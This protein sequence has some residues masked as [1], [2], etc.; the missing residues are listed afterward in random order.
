MMTPHEQEV[1]GEIFE[2]V[3]AL[4]PEE[5]RAAVERAAAGTPELRD[6]LLSLEASYT[7]APDF[8]EGVPGKVLSRMLNAL[9]DAPED[10]SRWPPVGARYQ[11]IERLGQ[12]GMG[13]VYKARDLRL[14]RLVALKLL[15]AHL[16]ADEKAR[17]RLLT[18]ARA[19]SMLDHPNIAVVHE[20]DETES[21]QLFISMACHEG[22]TLRQRLER[23]PLP[24]LEAIDIG[25]QVASALATTHAAAI[26]HRDI[27]PSNIL[28]T[29]EGVV[30]ILDFGIAKAAG[31]ELTREGVIV[32]TVAYM[33][34]EQTRSE[35]TDPSTDV[36]SLG[37]VLYQMLTSTRPFRADS[38]PALVHAIRYDPPLPIE[39]FRAD[40]PFALRGVVERCLAKHPEDR[41]QHASALA[42]DLEAIAR[43]PAEAATPAEV[44]RPADAPF[45]LAVLPIVD[46]ALDPRHSGIAAALTPELIAA[47]SAISGLRITAMA[48]VARWRADAAPSELVDALGVDG[49]V[50]GS[51]HATGS[52][53]H[54]RLELIDC[55][56]AESLWSHG[57]ESTIAQLGGSICTL[58]R[59]IAETLQIR[60]ST[61]EER[62]MLGARSPEHDAYRC[63]LEARPMLDRWDREA[64]NQAAVLFRRAVEADPAFAHAWSG[65]AHSLTKL[66]GLTA[67]TPT[68]AYSQARAAAERAL[69]LNEELPEAHT[70]LATALSYH[71]LEPRG[72]ERHFQ[73]AIELD[74]SHAA[75]RGFYAELLRN[76]GRFTE[77][78]TQIKAAQEL[79]PS[80][81]AH[82]FEEGLI[83][84]VARRYDEAHARL[85]R[86]LD[87]STGFHVAHFGMALVL[88]QLGRF[89]EALA[90]L[91]AL[92]PDVQSPDARSLRGYI[93]ARTGR[94]TEAETMIALLRESLSDFQRPF[95]PSPFHA[96]VILVGLGRFDEG[97]DL[98]WELHRERTWHAGLLKVEPMLDPLRTQ[99]RF[100]RLLEALGLHQPPPLLTPISRPR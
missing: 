16:A 65:L 42:A 93:Y 70:A 78:L 92:D 13:V 11:I 76:Q 41:Y 87:A 68:E 84:Y 97:L 83:L 55:R 54:T 45:R 36:W 29:R 28:I 99:P 100:Q 77:A 26:V 24:V 1:L 96:A 63:Y 49:C 98:L 74:P 44:V 50:R 64:A 53:I 69:E 66:A 67:L 90:E 51:V 3:A 47:L 30:K 72:A 75:A 34:P 23:G 2:A 27:K 43:M 9:L 10:A 95:D 4:P 82:A 60:V 94:R 40:V 15:P 19:A 22:E 38:T 14:G 33:S 8:L 79:N 37:V 85:R 81:P 58:A 59:G 5:R 17:A 7:L 71:Y 25:R 80:S 88:V 12:G 39:Q 73:R 61:D 32:G 46:D 6:E 52:R 56:S 31:E 48:S 35:V 86:L 57:I 21:G 89:D 18:E 20:I 91:Q 62:R